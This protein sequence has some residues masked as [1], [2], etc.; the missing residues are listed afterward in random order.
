MAYRDEARPDMGAFPAA[1]LAQP[2]SKFAGDGRVS[3]GSDRVFADDARQ[4]V[5]DGHVWRVADG[6]AFADVDDA[7]QHLL[8]A[9]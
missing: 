8:G 7:L 5:F 2:R 9:S 6:P 1:T 3:W 4:V